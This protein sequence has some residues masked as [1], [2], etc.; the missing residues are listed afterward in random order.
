[1]SGSRP[2]SAGSNTRRTPHRPDLHDFDCSEE[3]SDLRDAVDDLHQDLKRAR[4][5]IEHVAIL[6][7]ESLYP[8]R[9][10][11]PLYDGPTIE[12]QDLSSNGLVAFHLKE[13]DV[14]F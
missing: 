12:Q 1:M 8:V 6:V 5:V 10:P 11:E 13:D 2:Q 14:P 4:E 3:L 7:C 9:F